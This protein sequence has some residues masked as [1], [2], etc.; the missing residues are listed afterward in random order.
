MALDFVQLSIEFK[1]KYEHVIGESSMNWDF[2][3]EVLFSNNIIFIIFVKQ[4][5][6][7]LKI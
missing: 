3:I 1:D 4:L 7:L 6:L 2:V 5:K